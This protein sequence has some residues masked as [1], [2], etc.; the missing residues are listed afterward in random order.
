MLHFDLQVLNKTANIKS[1]A[2]DDTESNAQTPTANHV[3][4]QTTGNFNTDQPTDNYTTHNLQQ[5]QS[6]NQTIPQFYQYQ[7]QPIV[8]TMQA[9]TYFHYPSREQQ[10]SPES[11]MYQMTEYS[12]VTNVN[13]GW[14]GA[15]S[16]MHQN[17]I[18]PT[19]H[20]PQPQYAAAALNMPLNSSFHPPATTIYN[21][22]MPTADVQSKVV[23]SATQQSAPPPPLRSKSVPDLLK[24][25]NAE[26]EVSEDKRVRNT[27]QSRVKRNVDGNA[28]S[29]GE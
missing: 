17:H 4:D 16:T 13:G 6:T 8:T 23:Y 26:V 29:K 28:N 3:H 14:T 18:T 10:L 1:E 22:Q 24:E 21:Q 11:T 5:T 27:S 7:Q 19:Y 9:A 25:L 15:G 2:V 12:N 20:I